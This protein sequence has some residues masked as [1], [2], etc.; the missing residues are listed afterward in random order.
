MSLDKAHSQEAAPGSP[1]ARLSGH[2]AANTPARA[3]YTCE[4]LPGVACDEFIATVQQLGTPD[5]LP[6]LDQTSERS[7]KATSWQVV[8]V[9]GLI[10]EE[11][12]L[13]LLAARLPTTSRP[14]APVA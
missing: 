4:K 1:M 14:A 11:A 7:L 9:P 10:P 2:H 8:S 3:D 12:C 5:C 6:R 13:A